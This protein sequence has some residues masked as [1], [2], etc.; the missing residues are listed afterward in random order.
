MYPSKEKNIFVKEVLFDTFVFYGNKDQ[1][2]MV[3]FG[4][5]LGA[6]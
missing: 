1:K 3:A 6:D 5:K 4:R 2:Q